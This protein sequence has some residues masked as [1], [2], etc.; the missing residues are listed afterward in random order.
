MNE[1]KHNKDEQK[2]EA[3]NR[4]RSQRRMDRFREKYD[5]LK[6][7]LVDR[8]T[9]PSPFSPQSKKYY[10]TSPVVAP[11][12]LVV[13]ESVFYCQP[14]SP[15]STNFY[16][17]YPSRYMQVPQQNENLP[18]PQFTQCENPPFYPNPVINNPIVSPQYPPVT[19][20]NPQN[21]TN[22]NVN[23]LMVQQGEQLKVMVR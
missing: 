1:I 10:S 22:S 19:I 9:P 6:V 3:A 12:A 17:P 20:Q 18:M 2:E 14:Q 7:K 4:T 13:K 15:T 8:S 16:P 23:Q 11:P 21:V 5:V